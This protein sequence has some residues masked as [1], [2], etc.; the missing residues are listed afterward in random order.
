MIA[1]L[2]VDPFDLNL[3]GVLGPI[4]VPTTMFK[5]LEKGVG[6]HKTPN[7][8]FEV[9]LALR[10]VSLCLAF[11]LARQLALSFKFQNFGLS[12]CQ[13]FIDRALDRRIAS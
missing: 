8:A 12:D 2:L 7:H 11:S 1:V 5:S 13:P 4:L 9:E 6:R 3:G 10:V